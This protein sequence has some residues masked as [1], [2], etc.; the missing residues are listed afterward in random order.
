[1]EQVGQETAGYARQAPAGGAHRDDDP[2]LDRAKAHVGG[3]E[4][5]QQRDGVGEEMLEGVS[6]DDGGGHHSV[7]GAAVRRL[8][9]LRRRLGWG[10]GL[11]HLGT[12]F[13]RL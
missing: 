13:G 2:D 1:M 6:A 11:C 5:G 9:G 4:R 7:A 10:C 12:L 3:D 8:R